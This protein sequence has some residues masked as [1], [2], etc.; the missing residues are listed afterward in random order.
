LPAGRI[1]PELRGRGAIHADGSITPL[2]VI[3][4]EDERDEIDLRLAVDANGDARGTFTIVLRG[5]DAQE[6]AEMLLRSV[7]DERR[8]ALR[9]VA[10]AWVPFADVD[11]VTL[12]SNEESWQIALRADLTIPSYAEVAGA[13]SSRTWLLPGVDPL[14]SV[15]P[16]ASASTLGAT[17]AG[18]GKRQSALAIS[19][20]VQYHAHRRVELPSGARI[21]SLP[22]PFEVKSA[23]LEAS[24]SIAVSG[25]VIEDD[26]VLGV[27]TG[28]IPSRD[29]ETFVAD[30]HRT[31]DAFLAAT[32]VTP[33]SEKRVTKAK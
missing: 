25:A 1:S 22:G 31:D 17:Y 24:R 16:R 30:V 26:F 20:A 13:P 12:S 7:G 11:E 14:H 29:Y 27:P 19:H 6:I 10:L 5:R 23:R 28:T 33:A 2:P 21:A 18:Q 15:F 9:G 3:S 4:S 8:K 32:H